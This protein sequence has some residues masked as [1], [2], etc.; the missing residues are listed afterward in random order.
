MRLMARRALQA[1]LQTTSFAFVALHF[2]STTSF[3]VGP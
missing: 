2:G 1:G 3:G